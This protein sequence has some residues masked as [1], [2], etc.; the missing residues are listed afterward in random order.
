MLDG[1]DSF[2]G[3]QVLSLMNAVYQREKK[4]IIWTNF[5]S[6]F[7]NSQINMGFSRGYNQRQ[8][9]SHSYRKM[10]AF[11]SSHLKTFFVDLFKKIKIEDLQENDG[12]F[13]GGAS[14]TVMMI[15]MLE[16]ASP[17]VLYIP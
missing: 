14:D 13:Y 12:K 7:G 9:E 8:I 2:I 10:K 11:I 4:A 17:K 3:R 5:V 15:A 1:D 16:L 6:V